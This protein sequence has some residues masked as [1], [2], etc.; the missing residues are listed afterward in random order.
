[1]IREGINTLFLIIYIILMML[2]W[3]KRRKDVVKS[4][5]I[6]LQ[7]NITSLRPLRRRI[8]V[9]RKQLFY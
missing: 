2:L 4:D 8:N 6:T 1:M 5:I 7:H 9:P 3:R